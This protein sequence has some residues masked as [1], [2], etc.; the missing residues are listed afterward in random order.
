MQPLENLRSYHPEKNEK[1]VILTT[2]MKHMRMLS[3]EAKK[4]GYYSTILTQGLSC[5]CSI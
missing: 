5:S 4:Q 2:S 3:Q 1:I